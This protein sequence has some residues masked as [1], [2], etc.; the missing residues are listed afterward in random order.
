MTQGHGERLSTAD[1]AFLRMESRTLHMH[2]GTLF[3]FG[4][5]ASGGFDYARFVR[6]VRSRLPLVPRYRQRL[7]EPPF[8]VGNPVWVDDPDFDLSFHLRHASLP[9]P[10]TME[11][12]TEYSTRILSRTLD[13]GRP[14]WELYYIEGLEGDRFA[15]LAKSHHALVDGL[16][17]MDIATVLLDLSPS[18]GDEPAVPEPWRPEPTPSP[19]ALALDAAVHLAATPGA[20]VDSVRRAAHA[21][22]SAAGRALELSRGLA[23]VTRESIAHPPPRTLLNAAPGPHRR[24]AVQQIALDD[25]KEIK[26][27]F[28]TTVNDVVLALVAD[29]TGRYLRARG[30]RTDGVW[31]RAMVPV[32]TRSASDDHALGSRVIAAFVDLPMFEMDPVERLHVCHEAMADVKS[33][34][35]AVGAGFLVE[36]TGFAPPTLHAMAARLGARGRLFNFLVT[37]VPGPQVPVYCLGARL[38]AAYPFTP[39]ASNQSYSVGVISADGQLNFGVTADY[40]VLPDIG[41]IGGMLEAAVSELLQHA[42]AARERAR[43][44]EAG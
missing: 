17:G 11:Q 32:S 39:L 4:P 14:L 7:A 23:S 40:A 2:L 16:A 36:L 8:S 31:L 10:G 43:H 18:H 15:L 29:A 9:R 26:D 21:P 1:T 33:S 34:H 12:L 13:R 41:R 5:P 38:L 42:E 28:R 37:N 27:A 3:V 24:L 35:H 6:L 25:V 30:A 20:L 44:V 19:A 22:R